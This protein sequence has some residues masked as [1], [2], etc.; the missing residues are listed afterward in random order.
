MVDRKYPR[1]R[2][3]SNEK[4]PDVPADSLAR[5]FWLFT[6]THH[7][8]CNICRTTIARQSSHGCV[9]ACDDTPRGT[10]NGVEQHG[11]LHLQ[12]Q[13]K[14]VAT[15]PARN[16]NRVFPW[17]QTRCTVICHCQDTKFICSWQ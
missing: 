2:T 13:R 7:R 5:C 14:S 1:L 17:S 6:H 9:D 16:T 12:L 10:F 4:R 8:W 11:G 15:P 3:A